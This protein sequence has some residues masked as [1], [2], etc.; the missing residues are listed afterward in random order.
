MKIY[1]CGTDEEFRAFTGNPFKGMVHP[2]DLELV[3]RNIA[4]QIRKQNDL[5][6]AEY[7]IICKDGSEKYVRDYGRF[8]HTKEYGDVFYIFIHDVTQNKLIYDREM[9]KYTSLI[10]SLSRIYSALYYIDMVDNNG[11]VTF[12]LGLRDVDEEARH[13]LKQMEAVQWS[14]EH[15]TWMT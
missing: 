3:E 12:I 6:Y 8:I 9:N 2:D 13:Q 10:T 7:R 15:E 4:L 11:M 14:L 5:D 1:G